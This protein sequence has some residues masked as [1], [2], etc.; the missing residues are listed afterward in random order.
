MPKIET[1]EELQAER[2]RLQE[3]SRM[4]EKSLQSDVKELSDQFRPLY[5]VFEWMRSGKLVGTFRSIASVVDFLVP[6]PSGK[7]AKGGSVWAVVAGM[8]LET[9]VSR[10]DLSQVGAWILSKLSRKERMDDREMPDL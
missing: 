6:S 10:I 8:A 9:L 4:L 2:I 3:K 7:K 5:I 1:L